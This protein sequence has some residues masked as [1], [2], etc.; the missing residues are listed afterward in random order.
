M[1][2]YENYSAAKQ[3]LGLPD[4]TENNI[5]RLD[6][7]ERKVLQ[8]IKGQDEAVK[9]IC[10]NIYRA[11]YFDIKTNMLII[12]ESGTG[13][14]EII[15]QIAE[16]INLPY[17]IEDATMYTEEGYVGSSVTMMLANLMDNANKDFQKAEKGIL[18][19][20]E[21]DKKAK[22]KDENVKDVSGEG[23]IKS[24][25][26][27]MSGGIIN[28]KLDEK[29]RQFPFD[30]SN[31]IIICMGAFSEIEKIKEQ[32]IHPK[33]QIGFF[34][35]EKNEEDNKTVEGYIKSDIIEY[36][37]LEEFLGRINVIINT[38]PHTTESLIEIVRDSRLS[39]FRQ[40]EQALKSY[41]V[42]LEY[43]ET[44]FREIVEA[45]QNFNTGA[46]EISNIVNT[47]FENIFYEVLSKEPNTYHS[48]VMLTGIVKENTKYILK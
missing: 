31:L 19:I 20:D 23:V 47:L 44:I 32:R 1:S 34:V 4:P 22:S 26:T 30:T 16:E 46:R 10:I 39:V 6:E 45:I 7:L 40:Q 8:T 25:L 48:C 28:I 15:K 29:G 27:I 18:I 41:G 2:N 12:G 43:D 37:F 13:K 11:Y 3:A 17:T 33:S 36:G 42:N 5:P 21:I 24:L 9:R 14:T 35:E 38:K